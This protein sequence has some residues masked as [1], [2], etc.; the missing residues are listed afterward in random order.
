M[1]SLVLALL[2]PVLGLA[3]EEATTTTPP[4]T[5]TPTGTSGTQQPAPSASILH[6]PGARATMSSPL[7]VEPV[8]LTAAYPIPPKYCGIGILGE[9]R[10]GI[11]V[12]PYTGHDLFHADSGYGDCWDTSYWHKNRSELSGVIECNDKDS[13]TA[14]WCRARENAV[15]EINACGAKAVA[16]GSSDLESG[17]AW[18]GWC[19][20]YFLDPTN[21]VTSIECKTSGILGLEMDGVWESSAVENGNGR[22]RCIAAP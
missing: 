8:V 21:T 20:N 11:W 13:W 4:N 5:T 1:N 3:L 10:A 22:H 17:E 15:I 14:S 6:L 16:S 2:L 18:T 12:R 19:A 9:D 7:E